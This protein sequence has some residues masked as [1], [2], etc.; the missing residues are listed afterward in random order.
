MEFVVHILDELPSP[1]AA[2]R[3]DAAIAASSHRAQ[4]LISAF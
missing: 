1:S 2:Q 3:M 4:N